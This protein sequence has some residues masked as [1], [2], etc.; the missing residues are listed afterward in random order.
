MCDIYIC[1]LDYRNTC[2]P[3]QTAPAEL[4]FSKKLNSLLPLSQNNLS[5]KVTKPYPVTMSN[6]K[7]TIKKYHDKK[8]KELSSL[9]V[10]DR[11]YFKK[12]VNSS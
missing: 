6:R 11:I 9:N 2:K 3:Y 4:M 1:L 12:T 5:P 7:Q 10:G 8:G